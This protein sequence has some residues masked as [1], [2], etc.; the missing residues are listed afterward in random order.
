MG[1]R[2][3]AVDRALLLLEELAASPVPLATPE[4]ARRAG[5]NRATAWRLLN[6]LEHR[7][8]AERDPATGRYQVGYGAARIARATSLDSLARRSR[9]VLER[10]AQATSGSAYLL[11]A[12]SGSLVVVD[13]ARAAG[14]LLIDLAGID[15][16][17]HC[18]SVGKMHLSTWD[19]DELRDFLERPLPPFTEMTITEPARLRATLEEIRRSGVSFNFRD[20]HDDWCGVCVLVR[21]RAGRPLAY[22]NVTLPTVR[23]S[24]DDLDALVPTMK[25]AAGELEERLRAWPRDEAES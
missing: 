23:T 13:E 19:E 2:V 20:H 5:V 11:V 24:R 25:Q 4:L 8:L 3:Q 14:P 16:P 21:D 6:S 12:S 10:L 9:P 17:L 15:V 22:L 1:D 18:G 7:D